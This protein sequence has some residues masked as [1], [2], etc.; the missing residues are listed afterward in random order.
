MA[1]RFWYEVPLRDGVTTEMKLTEAEA[2]EQ[3]GS[4]AKKG[5]AAQTVGVQPVQR[6]EHATNASDVTER[7]ETPEDEAA[8][9]EHRI[10]T[11]PLGSADVKRAAPPQNK[12]R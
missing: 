1:D 11:R 2:K 9:A 12:R 5:R 10:E 7:P 8:P 6:P 3:Y 4:A